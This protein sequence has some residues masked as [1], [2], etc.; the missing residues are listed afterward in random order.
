MIFTNEYF[1][2]FRI[3]MMSRD[4]ENFI[5]ILEVNEEGNFVFVV[6]I[7]SINEEPRRSI[8]II[9]DGVYNITLHRLTLDIIRISS[10]VKM[11]VFNS[12][13]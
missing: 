5:S 12:H 9:M 11:I 6:R 7:T 13:E 3:E 1:I 4:G 10:S 2:I 8:I